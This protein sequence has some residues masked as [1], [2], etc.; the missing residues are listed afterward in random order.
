MKYSIKKNKAIRKPLAAVIL[1]VSVFMLLSGLFETR[2]VYADEPDGYWKY[3]DSEVHGPSSKLEGSTMSGG[4][5]HYSCEAVC[6]GDYYLENHDGSCRGETASMKIEVDEP[7]MTTLKPGQEVTMK[8]SAS[9]SAS[10]P[11]DGVLGSAVKISC[12]MGTN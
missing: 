2:K 7:P 12:N 5:G 11:H 1:A 10:T 6:E 8:V 9:V 4:H 3:T